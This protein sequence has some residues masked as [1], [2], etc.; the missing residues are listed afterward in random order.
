MQPEPLAPAGGA[1]TFKAAYLAAKQAV[2]GKRAA[3]PAAAVPAA[4]AHAAAGGQLEVAEVRALQQLLAARRV[5]G[6]M[7]CRC[8]SQGAAPPVSP[9]LPLRRSTS[10]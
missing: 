5:G 10:C 1:D 6:S 8:F 2:A 3:G 9:P 7:R 4:A